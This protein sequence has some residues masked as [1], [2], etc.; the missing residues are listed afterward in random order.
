MGKGN[1]KRGRDNE[2]W[3]AKFLSAL[4]GRRVFVTSRPRQPDLLGGDLIVDT[5]EMVR[6]SVQ[7]KRHKG[8]PPAWIIKAL[9]EDGIGLHRWDRNYVLLT[10]RLE[11]RK[12][13]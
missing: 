1:R 5:P 4:L 6:P 2:T 7:C 13:K 9:S 10:V 11:L 8:K 3:L 12:K